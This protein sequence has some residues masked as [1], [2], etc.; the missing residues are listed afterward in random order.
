[1]RTKIFAISVT[2][3]VLSG[4]GTLKK[5]VA[6][7]EPERGGIVF[8]PEE[9]DTKRFPE[10]DEKPAPSV[11]VEVPAVKPPQTTSPETSDPVVDE[12][13]SELIRIAKSKLGCK[14][15][16]AG[17]GPSTFDCSGFTGYVFRQIGINLAASSREQYSQGRA[18]KKD[19][20]LVPGDLVFFNGRSIGSTVGHVGIVVDY[21]KKTGV[22]TFIHA[23]VSTG[24]ELQKSNSEYYAQRYLGARRIL[25]DGTLGVL[26][27][28]SSH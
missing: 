10:V 9:Q 7:L 19:E 3:L 20:P 15:S 22:F 8:V 1:M 17:K 14:Y 27:A 11:K 28:T 12:I 4:C 13:Q 26:K 6:P 5:M 16:Y 18:L 25:T 21:N 23:A 2:V 24:V